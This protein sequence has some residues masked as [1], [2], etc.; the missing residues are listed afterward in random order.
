MPH[1]F[2]D[3]RYGSHIGFNFRSLFSFRRLSTE[4]LVTEYA[5]LGSCRERSSG[6]SMWNALWDFKDGGYSSHVGFR[7]RSL[8][9]V[10]HFC[11]IERS[12]LM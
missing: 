7:F 1:D 10:E 9:E 6:I 3:G 12:Q 5:I 8:F 11:T 2:Q 4:A